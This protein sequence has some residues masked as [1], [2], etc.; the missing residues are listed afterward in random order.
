M[1][2]HTVASLVSARRQHF[3]RVLGGITNAD[4]GLRRG[5]GRPEQSSVI[6]RDVNKVIAEEG[7]DR[8]VDRGTA[9]SERRGQKH[10]GPFLLLSALAL[11][12]SDLQFHAVARDVYLSFVCLY[13]NLAMFDVPRDRVWE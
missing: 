10:D 3:D 5:N 4:S 11:A 6:P 7:E 2:Q 8:L 12:N 1:S 9:L 13:A